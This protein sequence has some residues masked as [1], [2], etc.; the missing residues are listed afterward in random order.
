MQGFERG[1]NIGPGIK[2]DLNGSNL[3]LFYAL[4]A[5][6]YFFSTGLY[7]SAFSSYCFGETSFRLSVFW[8]FVFLY[9]S[10]AFS[11]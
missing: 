3:I 6:G 11:L 9:L 5:F 10:L 4:F 2:G 1:E 7:K 8:F